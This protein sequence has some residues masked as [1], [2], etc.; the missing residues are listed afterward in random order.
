MY[1]PKCVAVVFCLVCTLNVLAVKSDYNYA[2]A[3]ST[4]SISPYAYDNSSQIFIISKSDD[5]VTDPEI[6]I[7]GKV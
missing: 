7:S 1:Y 2:G 5:T 4:V 3:L 6:S